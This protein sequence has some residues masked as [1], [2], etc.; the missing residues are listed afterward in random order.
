MYVYW[1]TLSTT[2]DHTCM[3]RYSAHVAEKTKQAAFRFPLSL[4]RRL[5]AYADQMSAQM[6]GLRFSRADA[7]RVL[8]EKGLE[9]AGVPDQAARKKGKRR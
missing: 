2:I 1:F 3:V 5:D 4:L 9:E 7:V 6:P 8:L